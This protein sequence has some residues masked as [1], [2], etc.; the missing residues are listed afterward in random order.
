MSWFI[1][2][3]INPLTHALSNYLDKYLLSKFVREASAWSLA[4]FSSLAAAIV[5]P[6]IAIFHP[7]VIKGVSFG[8]AWFLM[9][10]GVGLTLAVVFYLKALQRYN[11]SSVATLFQLVPVF[12]LGLSYLVL[13]ETLNPRQLLAGM[14]IL[15]GG[16]IMTL[17][18]D[19]ER[20]Q[21]RWRLVGY[22]ALSALFYSINAVGFKLIAVEQGFWGSLF[23]DMLGKLLFGMLLLAVWPRLR[24]EFNE[25]IRTGRHHLWALTLFAE[26][27][28]LSGDLALMFAVL[29]APVALVQSVGSLQPILAFLLGLL[30]TKL[31]PGFFQESFAL[32]NLIKKM[33]GTVIVTSGV[34]LLVLT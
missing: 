2:A 27:I 24:K 5:L 3:L 6:V 29:Y 20:L 4:V 33:T 13:E 28:A 15:I 8:Q 32:K 1:I 34:L 19:T 14:L 26:A 17:Q 23:W 7:T 21:M 12:G 11:A 31:A 9:L 16:L 25:I 18:I 10:N 30:L 22:M